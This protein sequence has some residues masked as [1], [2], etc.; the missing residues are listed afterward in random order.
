MPFGIYKTATMLAAVEQMEPKH[1]FLRDRYFPHDP[2]KDVFLTEDVLVEYQS[3]SR[4][5]APCVMPRKGGITLDRDGYKTRSYAPPNVEPKRALSE[6]DIT[7]KMFGEAI[8]GQYTPAQ[9]AARYLQDDL[10]FLDESIARREEYVAAQCILN[11]GYILRHYADEYG[12]TL[13]EEKELRFYDESANPARYIPGA[14]VSSY[15]DLD[16]HIQLMIQMLSQ[17]GLPS[18]DL[19]IATDV[20]DMIMNDDKL[21][22]KLNALNY[23]IG[24]VNPSLMSDGAALIGRLNVRGKNLNLITYDA[25]YEDEDGTD[26][27]Y[28]P[29]GHIILTAPNAGRALY[30]AVTQMENKEFKTYGNRRVPKYLADEK[31]NTREIRMTSRPLFAPRNANPWISAKVM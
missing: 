3:G 25:T 22:T 18:T 12:G 5:M 16:P 30:G 28:I 2:E 1:N 9:R 31:S 10:I 6:D 21:L 13:F 19:I 24:T 4:K 7:K 27:P 8:M 14:L 29:A 11:N 17:K 23:N 26:K 20:A 15:E